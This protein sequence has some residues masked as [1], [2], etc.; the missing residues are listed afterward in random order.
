MSKYYGRFQVVE[1]FE[2]LFRIHRHD[3]SQLKAVSHEP[4]LAVLDQSDLI[5]QGIIVSEIVSGA[6]ANVDALGSCTANATTVALSNLLDDAKFF[7]TTGVASYANAVGAEKFA[8]KFYNECTDQ[9]GNTQTEWPPTD[10]GS[11]GPYIVEELQSTGLASGDKI[12]HTPTDIVSLLQ[13][14]GVLLGSPWF[15][16]WETPSASGFIDDEGI[17]GALASGVAGGHETYWWGVESLALTATGEVDPTK[18]VILGRNSWSAAW[19]DHG[20]YRAHLSTFAAIA[21]YCDW[22]QLVA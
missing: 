8:I 1:P 9:T 19:G 5:A 11:S 12:A 10:C 3:G 17:E 16:A 13:A 15:Y 18:T 4:P 2:G 22:R 6:P 20:N 14:S 7:T 21:Q